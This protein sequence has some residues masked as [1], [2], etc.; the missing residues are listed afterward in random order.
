MG[1]HQLRTGA[2]VAPIYGGIDVVS[3]HAARSHTPCVA[4]RCKGKIVTYME[5]SPS[6]AGAYKHCHGARGEPG[7]MC[8]ALSPYRRV[9]GARSGRNL[10]GASTSE[11]RQMDATSGACKVYTRNNKEDISQASRK[12]GAHENTGPQ[13]QPCQDTV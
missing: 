1:S 9:L 6:N 11:G 8:G 5:I 13:R 12:F 7:R 4:P 3:L 2:A 10:V